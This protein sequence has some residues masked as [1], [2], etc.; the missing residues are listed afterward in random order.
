MRTYDLA[1][2]FRSSI[3]FDRLSDMLNNSARPDWPPYNIERKGEN[4]YRISMAIAGFGPNEIELTQQGK[5]L[6]V[7]GAKSRPSRVTRR[8]SIRGS[9]IATSSKSSRSLPDPLLLTAKDG[10]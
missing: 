2:L 1:P 9:R 3:G 7:A 6:F 5:T 8:C 10:A 4:H